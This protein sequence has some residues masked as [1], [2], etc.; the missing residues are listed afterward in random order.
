MRKIGVRSQ[1]SGFSGV[2]SRLKLSKLIGGVLRLYKVAVSPFLP[3]ACRY[4][5]ELGVRF[6]G[7]GFSG[8]VSRSGDLH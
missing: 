6:Q 8:A 2:A 4:Y 5:P 3:S 7:S 1:G